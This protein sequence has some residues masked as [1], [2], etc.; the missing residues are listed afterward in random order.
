[1]IFNRTL[2]RLTQRPS[3]ERVTFYAIKFTAVEQSQI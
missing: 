3:Q 1:M 2:T